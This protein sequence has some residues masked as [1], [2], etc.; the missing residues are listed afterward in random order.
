M[1]G[2]RVDFWCLSGEIFDPDRRACR[3]GDNA[4]C[5]Y[6]ITP[7]PDDACIND[8]FA[9]RQHPDRFECQRFFV[10]LNYHTVAFECDPGF[11]FEQE[12][13]SCQPGDL[14]NCV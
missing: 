9:I 4:S 5:E 12:S 3:P 10:C 2:T 13:L 6:R 7:I 1:L 11:I 14:R 8:F